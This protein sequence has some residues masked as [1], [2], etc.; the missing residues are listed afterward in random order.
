MSCKNNEAN[1]FL[2][3]FSPPQEA[4]ILI[5]FRCKKDQLL[6]W[7]LVVMDN[8]AAKRK[9][10]Y[11]GREPQE[12]YFVRFYGGCGRIDNFMLFLRSCGTIGT[13]LK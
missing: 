8:L 3:V 6:C 10:I 2:G 11:V 1:I 13:L 12:G 7:A 9:L 4:L 5:H